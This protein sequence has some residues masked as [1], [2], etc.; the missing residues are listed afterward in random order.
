[1]DE[2]GRAAVFAELVEH[3]DR[4]LDEPLERRQG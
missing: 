1:M 3:D 2:C 4:L